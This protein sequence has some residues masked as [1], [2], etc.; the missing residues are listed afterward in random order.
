M[1]SRKVFCAGR[2]NIAKEQHV[3]EPVLAPPLVSASAFE[4][5]WILERAKKH[6]PQRDVRE[7]VGVMTKLMMNSMRFRALENEAN[8]R[9]RF[10]IPMIKELSDCD[11]DRVITSGARAGAKQWIHHQTA[12]DGI[13]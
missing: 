7:V 4:C 12:Q 2:V 6:V 5:L 13:N 1:Q 10:D 9:R 11:Q 8:P 3:F